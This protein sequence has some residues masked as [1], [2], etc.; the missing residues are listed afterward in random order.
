[1]IQI[2][3]A[4][5]FSYTKMI[6]FQVELLDLCTSALCALLQNQ[7]ALLELIPSMGHIPRLCR[8]LGS[9]IRQLVVPKSAICILNSL[10]MN[11][12][13]IFFKEA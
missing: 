12:V 7:P 8:Q 3:L 4:P 10:S 5:H 2:N 13:S 9:N 1:M 6:I 11:T